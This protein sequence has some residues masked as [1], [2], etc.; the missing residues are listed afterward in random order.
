[1]TES[2][3]LLAVS[4]AKLPGMGKE[5]VLENFR[6]FGFISISSPSPSFLS[7]P[8]NPRVVLFIHPST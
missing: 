3:D 4:A 2:G 5:K 1:M 6:D 8:S 7:N